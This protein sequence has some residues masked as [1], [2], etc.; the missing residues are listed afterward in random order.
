P[1]RP[2]DNFRVAV[3]SR[4]NLSPQR[5]GSAW[6]TALNAISRK[7]KRIHGLFI[8]SRP[9]PRKLFQPRQNIVGSSKGLRRKTSAP[10]RDEPRCR[11]LARRGHLPAK[12]TLAVWHVRGRLPDCSR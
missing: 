11:R 3:H 12:G 5:R 8:T 7:S 1:D 4:A 9:T 6:H 2:A 10:P